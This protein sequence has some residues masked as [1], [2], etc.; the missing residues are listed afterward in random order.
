MTKKEHFSLTPNHLVET[1]RLQIRCPEKA[2]LSILER[3]FGD[4]E[5][6]LY[7]GG[8]WGSAQIAEI[9]QEWHADWGVNQRW[10][11]M[12]VLK[13]TG[14]AI[15]TAGITA[16]T[17]LNEPGLELSWFVLPEY[18]QQGYA[19]EITVA[20]LHFAFEDLGQGRVV[21]ETHPENPASQ[22]VLEKLGFCCLGERHHEYDYLPGFDTQSL[23][24]M[25][26]ENWLPKSALSGAPHIKLT[27]LWQWVSGAF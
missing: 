6:M 20:L 27:R 11:G 9:L 10:S 5:M 8:A 17:I 23:W 4:P 2:D 24:E 3:V 16:N 18:Q 14:A 22:R 1:E 12:L 26:C 21:V 15:G 25:T 7:L 19:T 13:A